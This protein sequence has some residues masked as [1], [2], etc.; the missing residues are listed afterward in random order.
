MLQTSVV[1][2]IQQ[3]I[4]QRLR[5]LPPDASLRFAEVNADG[6]PSDQFSYHLRQLQ[7][8]GLV[9]KRVDGT[10]SLSTQGKSKAP[11]IAPHDIRLT[12][13]GYVATR[14]VLTKQEAGET[15]YLLQKRSLNPQKGSLSTPGGK[16]LGGTTVAEV[17][18]H[19]MARQTGLTCTV[20]VKGMVHFMD[21]YQGEVVQ[22]RYFLIFLAT[23]PVGELSEEGP[24]GE[25]LWL[26]YDQIKNMP[27]VLPAL[28]TIIDIACGDTPRFAE[29]QFILDEF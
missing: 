22:D 3:S 17:A 2:E 29:Q 11:L 16:A 19:Y 15:Y 25:N 26:T 12:G 18:R 9:I 8:N 24:R 21:E 5:T 20:Q 10:Y 14:I 7:R 27:E 6:V 28:L 13:Q 1:N 23:D 4:L